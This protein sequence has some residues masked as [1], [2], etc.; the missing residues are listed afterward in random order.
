[1]LLSTCIRVSLLTKQQNLGTTHKNGIKKLWYIY[2]MEYSSSIKRNIFGSVLMR[3][4]N[5]EPIMQSEVSQK[6]K[7]KY[8]SVYIWNL[9]RWYWWIYWQGGN[10]DRDIENRLTDTGQGKERVRCME[11]VTW[12]LTSP[13]VKETANENL[14]YDS[15]NLNR[16]SV[17]TQR[18]GMGR[19]MGGSFKTEVTYVYQRLI[20]VDILQK[21]TKFCK[22]I[23]LQLKKKSL[24]KNTMLEWF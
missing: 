24:K 8:R 5:L 19:E 16:D 21:T 18:R 23:I 20:H 14:L 2:T 4:M 1:M 13:Y 7:D 15:G 6:E 11:R 22:A 10:G 9:E 17:S 12:K 3:W